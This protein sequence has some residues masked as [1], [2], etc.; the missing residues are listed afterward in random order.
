VRSTQFEWFSCVNVLFHSNHTNSVWIYLLF[1][2]TTFI[3]LEIRG[4][5]ESKGLCDHPYKR[6]QN[7][8]LKSSKSPLF[9]TFCMGCCKGPCDQCRIA[10][11]ASPPLLEIHLKLVQWLKR[12]G[13]ITVASS[14]SLKA[15]G[16]WIELSVNVNDS[17]QK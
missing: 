10:A 1:H 4:G 2:L 3:S 15:H 17:N 12:L 9:L 7:V 5:L 6:I 14:V 13:W 11:M 8:P 16:A